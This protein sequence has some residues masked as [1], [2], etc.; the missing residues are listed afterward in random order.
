[1]SARKLL[2][3]LGY[4][5]AGIVALL[6]I[7]AVTAYAVSNYRMNR[8]FDVHVTG[9]KVPADAASIERGRHLV[10]IRSCS[11]CHGEDFGGRKVID[12]PMAGVFW[13]ANLTHGEGGLPSDFSDLDYVRAIRHGLSRDG[14]GL[15]LMPSLEYTDMSDEDLGAIIAFLKTVPPVNRPRGPVTPGPAVRLLLTLGKIK[16]AAELIDHSALRQNSVPVAVT[17]EYGK[18]L[19]TSCTGCH[20]SNLSGGKING[21][22]PDWPAA[23]NL[24][25]HASSHLSQ[26]TEEQFITTL[27]THQRPD[28]TQLNPMMPA[29]VG[30][31]SDVELKALWAYLSSLPPTPTGMR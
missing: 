6:A 19:A 7:T 3:F 23:A 17:A 1:M 25:Q 18:Y 30:Q 2:K 22:P 20:G 9:V 24:T 11:D 5:L 13:G 14:R 12:D 8:Q 31:M 21:A 29:A 4:G 10:A 15:R 26:W 16:V 27:R 28:G